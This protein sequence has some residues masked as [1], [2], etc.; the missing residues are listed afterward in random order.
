LLF[1]ASL[2]AESLSGSTPPA[3]F[4]LQPNVFFG[5]ALYYG[6]GAI[7]ARELTLRWRKGWPTTLALGAAFGVLQEGLGTKVFFDP[8]R[9]ELSPLV[10]YGTTAGVQPVFVVQLVIYHAVYSIGLP[11]LLAQ[12]L[13]PTRR[14]EPWVGRV[15]LVFCVLGLAL[16]TFLLA[17]VYPY[18]PAPGLTALTALA[19]AVLVLLARLL[20]AGAR[21]EGPAA[22]VPRPRW[23]WLVG[24]LTTFAFFLISFGFPGAHVP[25]PLT[26]LALVALAAGVGWLL[27]TRSGGGT[28]LT[29]RHELALASG[30]LS[31]FILVAPLQEARG[32][33]GMSLVALGAAVLLWWMWRRLSRREASGPPGGPP[34]ATAPRAGRP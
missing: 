20:P 22:D 30:L 19:V 2:I 24:A 9:T 5:F 10:N 34:P 26:A 14:A 15:G 12:L 17:L 21:P 28:A 25:P 27:F 4:F 7:L 6:S 8:G 23:F 3:T 13:F 11:I 29:E 16:L 33:T 31:P 18:Q 1:L 32:N